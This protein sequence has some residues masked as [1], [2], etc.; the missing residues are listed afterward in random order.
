MAFYKELEYKNIDNVV[1]IQF[2]LMSPE[3]I[4]R[5]SVVEIKT[6]DTYNGNE[7][8]V[9]GLFDERMGV[10]EQGKIC[11][12]DGLNNKM[13]P[14]YFGHIELATP[15]F[16]Y[17]FISRYI[18]KILE[19]ICFRCSKL[20]IGRKKILEE[21]PNF[22][23]LKGQ[24]RWKMY[25]YLVSQKKN[26]RCGDKC[27]NGCMALFPSKYSYS[28]KENLSKICAEWKE[29]NSQGKQ[30]MNKTYLTAGIVLKIFKRITDDDI[31][32]L[33]F[34]K[35]WS[36]PEWMIC[37]VL[38]VPPPSMRPSVTQDNSQRMED[39]LTSKLID[40]LKNN[41]E[42]KKKILANVPNID[43]WVTVL[44]YHI[45]TFMNNEEQQI[46][47]AITRSMRPI[48]SIKQRLEGKEG[49]I[50]GNLMGKRVDYS[51]RSVITPDPNINIDELG[52]P[53]KI[54]MNLTY[55][56]IVTKYNIDLLQKLVDNGPNEYPGAKYIKYK[57]TNS[58]LDL[59][60]AK[61][62]ILGYGDIVHRHLMN[63]DIV[64]FNRQPSLHKL[65]MM[66]HKVRVM[67]FNTFRLNVS[68]TTPYNA[69]FDGDE[70]N[71]HVPQCIHTQTELRC[72][73]LVPLQ[74]ISPREI[75]PVISIVQDTL[76]GVYRLTKEKDILFNEREFMNIMMKNTNFNGFVNPKKKNSFN[77]HDIFT[78]VL[79]NIIYK[80]NNP[81]NSFKILKGIMKEGI[82]SV[83][84][85]SKSS[86]GLIHSIYND[87]GFKETQAFIDNV[88][89][90]ITQYLLFTGFS[91]GI[92]D[93]IISNDIK[94]QIKETIKNKSNEVFELMQSIHL[95]IFKNIKGKTNK[96]EFEEKC[97]AIC[98]QAID[99]GNN[100][101][102]KNLNKQN[103][104]MDM[105]KSGSKGK[106]LN[107]RQIMCSLGQQ[108]IEKK[109]IPDGFTGRSLPHYNKYDDGPEAR[110][111][112]ASSF[113]NGLNPQEFYFHAMG[114]RI[115]LID[116][117]VKT[118]AT[119]YIQR[120]LI[121]VLEDLKVV[122][123]YSV[124][125]ANNNIVQFL[126][127]EDGS[128]ST[129]LE[130]QKINFYNIKHIDMLKKFNFKENENWSLFLED[131][132]IEDIKNND[133]FYKQLNTYYNNI[134]H[135]KNVFIEFVN[136]N[137]MDSNSII[138]PIHFERSIQATISMFHLNSNVKSNIHPLFLYEEIEAILKEMKEYCHFMKDN[139]T[140]EVA[141][142]W[143][144]NPYDIIK[145]YRFTKPA[146]DYL[147][148]LILH[149]YKNSFIEPGEMV[150]VLAAQSIG[151][152]AT[153]MTLN[154]FHL[155]GVGEVANKISGVPRLEE[156]LRLAKG[157][158]IKT[159]SIR[160]FLDSDV[161]CDYDKA[162]KVKN[163]LEYIKLKDIILS[164]KIYYDPN[165]YK[166]TIKEDK[167]FMDI[168]KEFNDIYLDIKEK[169]IQSKLL[170]RF[171]F[172]KKVMLDKDITMDE[173]YLIISQH[174]S[175]K[176]ISCMYS[177]DNASKLVFRFRIDIP[178]KDTQDQIVFLKEYERKLLDM[179]IKGIKNINK[180][181]LSE[182]DRYGSISPEG[183]LSTKTQWI[184]NTDGILKP[185]NILETMLID[186]V[187]EHKISCNGIHEIFDL[188]GIEAAR[189]AL[190]YELKETFNEA[191]VNIN[192]RHL[193]LLVDYMTYKGSLIVMTRDG[194]SKTDSGPIAKCS[195]EQ[196]HKNLLT[197]SIFGQVDNMKGVSSNIMLGQAAPCGTG[198]SEVLL[199]EVK[200]FG[201]I[202][203][204]NIDA[205][206]DSDEDEDIE[207]NIEEDDLDFDF[208]ME[209]AEHSDEEY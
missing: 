192:Y 136:Y 117:A 101:N 86:V 196:A 91:V 151:E 181:Y 31:E 36:R 149:K 79:P 118:S 48:K 170:L 77:G 99:E 59:E 53:L 177:D 67:K 68:V 139:K 95:N 126:Y 166:T 155:A 93:I 138:I 16:H 66:A 30:G 127:G 44:Q 26:I 132:V 71:M 7:P 207:E 32:T 34:S 18:T 45:T 11:P 62:I 25:N 179:K 205:K 150:G 50:R 153:Q 58:Q 173:I 146:L 121:K 201:G 87:F 195:F 69:D 33:G 15:I 175:S 162:K 100:I 182:N 65:S 74:I 191:S 131:S 23:K 57:K 112:V 60:Y 167:E 27:E 165:D 204:Y 4:R 128:E 13:C 113:I 142:K 78:S 24:S 160:V 133:T 159:P 202:E 75:K 5:R 94:D 178:T 20:R 116:T 83:N 21:C 125:T 198:L 46:S 124:R 19:C 154:T 184:I 92:S 10:L 199:D 164:T 76:L 111:F 89:G 98:V 37:T 55:P 130:V 156:L 43:G 56:E 176:S 82:L 209:M 90:I 137:K 39:D 168:Y 47:K 3:E 9:E 145:K 42:L 187:D 96:E 51:A 88:Q 40:I 208:N 106:E 188:F 63:G 14:G 41:D 174:N 102:K 35:L 147:K 197:S 38:A 189:N 6:T 120:R 114:G 104:M 172:D 2:G 135:L 108:D 190:F 17:Q 107:L 203:D 193:S 80:N 49:R 148:L 81:D 152:P 29:Q 84:D 109:R 122:Y 105:I 129:K 28:A 110:G 1:G 143:F 183:N 123:D 206:S 161:S 144:L 169:D 171:E 186:G 180:V 134:N 103:R 157:N 54:A 97:L 115:G 185:E 163:Q 8:A 22:Y 52:V 61:D 158:K 194:L 85:F 200:L 73:V 141:I 64:L 119:G 140:L 72:L 12:T 70:M